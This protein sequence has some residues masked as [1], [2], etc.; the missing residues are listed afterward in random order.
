MSFLHEG[1]KIVEEE[2]GTFYVRGA[3]QFP[4]DRV[5]KS[6]ADILS[7]DGV[8]ID[9]FTIA[10]ANAQTYTKDRTLSHGEGQ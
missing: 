7:Q 10:S 2:G 6:K 9:A 5:E 1:N 3:R 8:D 4:E